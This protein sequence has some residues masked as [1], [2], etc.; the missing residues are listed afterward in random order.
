MLHCWLPSLYIFHEHQILQ[1]SIFQVQ[2]LSERREM[3]TLKNPT[4]VGIEPRSSD[5]AVKLASKVPLHNHIMKTLFIYLLMLF[6]GIPNNKSLFSYSHLR[7]S[8][9]NLFNKKD[10]LVKSDEMRKLVGNL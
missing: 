7:L 9:E 3:I 5:I 2:A 4:W 6:E 8:S 1:L 10:K